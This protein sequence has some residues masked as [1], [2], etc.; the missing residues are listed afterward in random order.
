M[1]RPKRPGK[2]RHGVKLKKNAGISLEP[3]LIEQLDAIAIKEGVRRSK[4]VEQI[5]KQFLEST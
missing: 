1:P 2:P 4:L 5:I 3:A